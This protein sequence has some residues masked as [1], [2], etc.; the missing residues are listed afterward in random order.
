MK[1]LLIIMFFFCLTSCNSDY[2]EITKVDKTIISKEIESFTFLINSNLDEL[3]LTSV[4]NNNQ[5]E[6]T[7]NS[8]DDHYKLELVI[9][10]PKSFENITFKNKSQ[11]YE[12]SIG[13]VE[14]IELKENDIEQ[15]NIITDESNVIYIYN[16]LNKFIMIDEIKVYGGDFLQDIKYDY[17]INPNVLTKLGYIYTDKESYVIS[18]SF[19]CLGSTYEEVVE[20]KNLTNIY[21]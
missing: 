5:F 11:Q 13:N 12:C 10:N 16:K 6:Y 14:V 20:I 7:I 9:Y 21:S 17:F 19:T 8:F 3:V 15:I 4:E 18:I 1:Y 2:I